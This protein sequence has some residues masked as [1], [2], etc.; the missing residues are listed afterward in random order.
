MMWFS[1]P[2]GWNQDP[3][4]SDETRIAVEDPAACEGIH[5]GLSTEPRD[6]HHG[7]VVV[8]GNGPVAVPRY[9]AV[10]VYIGDS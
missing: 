9:F 1:V 4:E 2:P 6:Y 5:C 10:P 7:H 3:F 8:S